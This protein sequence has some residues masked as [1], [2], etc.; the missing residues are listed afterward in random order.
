MPR[1]EPDTLGTWLADC[2]IG[3]FPS[4]AEGFPLAV[5]EMLAAGVPVVAYDAPGAPEL[6]SPEPLVPPGDTRA[7]SRAVVRMLRDRELLAESRRRARR[8]SS[9]FTW[10]DVAARTARAYRDALRRKAS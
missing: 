6:L 1:F 9:E 3:I 2:A 4:Y 5:L 10:D 7:M 8:R